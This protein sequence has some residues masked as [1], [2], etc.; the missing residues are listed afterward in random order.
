MLPLAFSWPWPSSP[1]I[2]FCCKGRKLF[3][4]QFHI[5]YW[6]VYKATT[7][8]LERLPEYSGLRTQREAFEITSYHKKTEISIREARAS[9]GILTSHSSPKSHF[10]IVSLIDDP[11]LSLNVHEDDYWQLFAREQSPATAGFVVIQAAV[12]RMIKQWAYEWTKTL[13]SFDVLETP[14][15]DQVS[16]MAMSNL[17]NANNLMDSTRERMSGPDR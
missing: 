8:S 11:G 6:T 5:R 14:G 2:R 4:A 7:D 3:H 1:W 17:S 15:T 12:A 10:S 16:D 13:E 9:V